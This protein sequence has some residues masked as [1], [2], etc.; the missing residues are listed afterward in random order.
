[1]FKLLHQNDEILTNDVNSYN[2]QNKINGSIYCAT[3]DFYLKFYFNLFR[4]FYITY[5]EKRKRLEGTIQ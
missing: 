1:M 2:A 5:I 3:R 4:K